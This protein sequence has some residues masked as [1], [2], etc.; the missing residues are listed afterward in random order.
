MKFY[1]DRHYENL[2][3]NNTIQEEISLEFKFSHFANGE[4]AEFKFRLL[5]YFFRNLLM[6]AYITEIQKSKFANIKFREFDHSE[7]SGY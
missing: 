5:F 2:Q 3:Y 7:P 6:I 1:Q 4:V